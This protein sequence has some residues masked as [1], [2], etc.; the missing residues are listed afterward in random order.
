M[1]GLLTRVGFRT[2]PGKN[3]TCAKGWAKVVFVLFRIFYRV[4]SDQRLQI[5]LIAPLGKQN[6]NGRH[7]APQ[8]FSIQT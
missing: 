7:F 1:C 5:S 2:V 4:G 3:L 8:F 6:R